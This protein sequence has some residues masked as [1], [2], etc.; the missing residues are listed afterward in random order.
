MKTEIKRGIRVEKYPRAVG[1]LA[2]IIVFA[3]GAMTA[4]AQTISKK[5]AIAATTTTTSTRAS[6]DLVPLSVTVVSPLSGPDMKK[7]T[8]NT[9]LHRYRIC[10][11]N[12]GVTTASP[13]GDPGWWSFIVSYPDDKGGRPTAYY[14]SRKKM[15]NSVASGA[16]SC[17]EKDIWI[18]YCRASPPRIR[19]SVDAD[20]GIVERDETNNRKDF[21]PAAV[22]AGD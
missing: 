9:V 7:G 20:K 15:T 19:V 22:C 10:A 8:N 14:W 1:V 3:G 12:T 21:Y 2:A 13:P 18:S 4:S 5:D 11:K 17:Y 16:T 6:P